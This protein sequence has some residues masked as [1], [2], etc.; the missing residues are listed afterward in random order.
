MV[1]PHYLVL[2]TIYSPNSILRS[3]R[4]VR[5]GKRVCEGTFFP[6][7]CVPYLCLVN[8]KEGY[9]SANAIRPGMVTDGG[10]A[11]D[12]QWSH[13]QGLVWEQL[14]PCHSSPS[15]G[16]LDLAPCPACDGVF[17]L[18]TYK[19]GHPF[20]QLWAHHMSYC[21]G[22]EDLWILSVGFTWLFCICWVAA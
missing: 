17:C 13:V 9:W 18:R 1:E 3:N 21:G 10:R 4:V 16:S 5:Q 12:C 22:A 8:S 19:S 6:H 15:E 7:T 14:P 11:G 20:H 2:R